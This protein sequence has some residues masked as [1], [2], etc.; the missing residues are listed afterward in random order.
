MKSK[1]IKNGFTLIEL[2]VAMGLF[3]V[4][5]ILASGTFVRALR[6]ERQAVDLM[7]MNDSAS[8]ALEQ[9]AREIR[10][11]TDF[12]SPSSDTVNF[13]SASSKQISYHFNSGLGIVQRSENGGA[14]EPLT[15][16]NVLVSKL[17]FIT[18]GL[19]QSDNLPSRITIVLS[20]GSRSKNLQD[21]FTNLETTIS[22]RSF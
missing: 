11:S 19:S 18:A 20:V 10:T 17:V 2:L 15:A 8:L 22:P 6:I 7:A 5:V 14:F 1:N 12:S 16:T 4:V 13:T 21:I 3:L 9:M